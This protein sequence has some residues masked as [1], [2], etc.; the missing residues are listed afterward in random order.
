MLRAG[1]SSACWVRQPE[2]LCPHD[3]NDIVSELV[4]L[5]VPATPEPPGWLAPAISDGMAFFTVATRRHNSGA[6][7]RRPS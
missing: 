1:L 2:V 3:E 5:L 4:S 6:V 7:Y